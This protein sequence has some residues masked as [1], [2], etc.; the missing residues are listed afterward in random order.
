MRLLL[1]LPEENDDTNDSCSMQTIIEPA[2]YRKNII[3]Q[4]VKT[5]LCTN[6]M[7]LQRNYNLRNFAK[8]QTININEQV[9]EEKLS[10]AIM[11]Q[12]LLQAE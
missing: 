6:D 1:D 5:I 10:K 11:I 7:H 2:A 8:T 12:H 3:D 9:I 4:A